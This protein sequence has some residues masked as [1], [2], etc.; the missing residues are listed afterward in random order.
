MVVAFASH[1][2]KYSLKA[3]CLS[4]VESRN[5]VRVRMRCEAH[6]CSHY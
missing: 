5:D 1:I 2:M 6:T 4:S 3:H